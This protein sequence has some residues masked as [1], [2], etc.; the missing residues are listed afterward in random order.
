VSSGVF[1][2]LLLNYFKDIQSTS[3]LNYTFNCVSG[4]VNYKSKSPNAILIMPVF[5]E[6]GLLQKLKQLKTEHNYLKIVVFSNFTEAD[7]IGTLYIHGI[8]A[9]ISLNDNISELLSAIESLMQNKTYHSHYTDKLISDYYTQSQTK[10]PVKTTEPLTPAEKIVLKHLC[11]GLTSPQIA[12][13]LFKSKNTINTHRKH[14]YNKTGYHNIS[15][16][17]IWGYKNNITFD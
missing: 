13:I 1:N 10:T 15:D 5:T 16:L 14:I 2:D 8:H 3:K 4:L 12:E 6:Q 17:R 7:F 11:N 9:H